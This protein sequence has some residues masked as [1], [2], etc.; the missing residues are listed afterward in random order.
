MFAFDYCVDLCESMRRVW[1]PEGKWKLPFCLTFMGAWHNPKFSDRE[2][3][4]HAVSSVLSR[5]I[6]FIPMFLLVIGQ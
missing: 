2:G 6:E 4:W 3:P 5:N 1:F